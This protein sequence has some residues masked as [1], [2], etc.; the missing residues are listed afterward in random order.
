MYSTMINVR[1]SSG[2]DKTIFI[3]SMSKQ[4]EIE[5]INRVLNK[6]DIKYINYI[7]VY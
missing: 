2:I 5:V 6:Y 7:K 3:Y 4:T 1:L